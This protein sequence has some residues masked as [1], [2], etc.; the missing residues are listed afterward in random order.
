MGKKIK[1]LLMLS[2]FSLVVLPLTV[3]AE[4]DN[5]A[6]FQVNVV[7]NTPQTVV[8]YVTTINQ[9][10][11]IDIAENYNGYAWLKVE[12][13]SNVPVKASVESIEAIGNNTVTTV[14]LDELPQDTSKKYVRVGTT[15]NSN[16]EILL[17][18]KDYSFSTT[19][20]ADSMIN[21]NSSISF[22]S[23]NDDVG[24][25]E[26]QVQLSDNWVIEESDELTYAVTTVIEPAVDVLLSETEYTFASY[27]EDTQE[28]YYLVVSEN[29]TLDETTLST[30]LY[31][32]Q[33]MNEGFTS[34]VELI[35]KQTVQSDETTLY[36]YLYKGNNA[37]SAVDYGVVR[38]SV[39]ANPA[40]AKRYIYLSDNIPLYSQY[41]K[42]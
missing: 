31:Y 15:Y 12:N 42:S 29:S 9:N 39:M 30:N 28:I 32:G 26:L 16:N 11:N 36:Y 24:L 17:G 19:F 27:D 8:S 4:T 38:A 22:T 3:N 21:G 1:N 10:I 14:G 5:V 2:L 13:L 33:K 7:D 6:E 41:K 18:Q 37:F 20:S 23:K 35:A 34:G 40:P 25:F